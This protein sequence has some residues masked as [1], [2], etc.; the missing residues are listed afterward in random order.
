MLAACCLLVS[1]MAVNMKATYFSGTLA[2]FQKANRPYIPEYVALHRHS[3]KNLNSK[4]FILFEILE[5]R[6][7]FYIH[8]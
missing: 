1:G 6:R 7:Y 2:D 8:I 4:I 3:C 5:G